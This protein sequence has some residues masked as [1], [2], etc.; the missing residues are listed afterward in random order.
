MYHPG[1]T[2]SVEIDVGAF[3]PWRPAATFRS[4]SLA[5]G[6]RGRRRCVGRD[7]RVAFLLA[8][9]PRT[10]WPQRSARKAGASWTQGASENKRAASRRCC[11]FEGKEESRGDSWLSRELDDAA[12]G[13]AAHP[14]TAFVLRR[15]LRVRDETTCRIE[16]SIP[17][18]TSRSSPYS[19][20]RQQI[21]ALYGSDKTTPRRRPLPMVGVSGPRRCDDRQVPITIRSEPARLIPGQLPQGHSSGPDGCTTRRRPRC[22]GGLLRARGPIKPQDQVVFSTQDYLIVLGLDC[23]LVMNWKAV[24]RTGRIRIGADLAA[25][26]YGAVRCHC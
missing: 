9:G 16:S 6:V 12:I 11:S 20:G 18:A 19:S 22:D 14:N 7:Q 15:S 4:R 8:V 25:C 23:E 13:R 2:V 21:G 5:H 10:P 24:D 1:T 26:V 3:G 17:S